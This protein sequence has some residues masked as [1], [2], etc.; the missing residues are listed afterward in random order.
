MKTSNKLLIAL[1]LG[2]LLLIGVIQLALYSNWKSGKIVSPG[3]LHAEN[4]LKYTLPPPSYISISGVLWVN[5]IPSDTFS[6]E[7]PKANKVKEKTE[8]I[9]QRF[10][11]DENELSYRQSGDTLFISG[12]N[13]MTIHRPYADWFYRQNQMQV[14]IYGRNLKGIS[15]VNGQLVFRGTAW[16]SGG[17]VTT[18]SVDSSTVWIGDRELRD[19]KAVE[20]EFFNHIAIRSVN[21]VI[22]LNPSATIQ[23]LHTDLDDLSELIDQKALIDSIRIGY[24]QDSRIALTG[25]NLKKAVLVAHKN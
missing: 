12:N 5:L 20:T 7:F 2:I 18:L 16:P 17:S 19:G 14:N 25:N 9:P 13:K 15:L 10:V 8:P 24:D 21:S 23:Q 22:L 3:T 1:A 4:Y 6:I 11:N